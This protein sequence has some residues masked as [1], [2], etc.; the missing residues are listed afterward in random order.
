MRRAPQ[1]P[2]L[3]DAV[4]ASPRC[5]TGLLKIRATARNPEAHALYELFEERL[6]TAT[7]QPPVRWPA[8]FGAFASRPPRADESV[9]SLP[10]IAPEQALMLLGP[11]RNLDGPPADLY[12]AA[13]E[14]SFGDD[15]NWP[16]SDDLMMRLLSPHVPESWRAQWTSGFGLEPPSVFKPPALEATEHALNQLAAGEVLDQAA[17]GPRGAMQVAFT[18]TTV[19][20]GAALDAALPRT[21]RSAA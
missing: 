1:W 9:R 19:A 14:T 3:F 6:C 13:L 21:T 11:L 7:G 17:L 18:Y 20:I 4:E 15:S 5:L 2:G 8:R 16:V 12:A 10:R